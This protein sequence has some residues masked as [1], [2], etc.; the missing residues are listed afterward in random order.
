M[1][2]SLRKWPAALL[3]APVALCLGAGLAHAQTFDQPLEQCKAVTTPAALTTCAASQDPLKGGGATISDEGDVTVTVFGAATNTTYG[4]TFVSNDRTQTTS[5]GSLK[6]NAAGNGA[7]AQ[8]RIF[9]IRDGRRRQRGADQRA[10]EQFVTGLN[11]SS[12][13]FEYAA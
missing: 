6:T 7:I 10:G 11:V 4:V 2:L 12:S 3:A 9:Q 5:I 13:G 8:G 1:F